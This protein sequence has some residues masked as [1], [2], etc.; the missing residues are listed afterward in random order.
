MEIYFGGGGGGGSICSADSVQTLQNAA[1]DQGLHCLLTGISEQD[2][3][4]C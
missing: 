1:Y 4:K 3:K 2:K